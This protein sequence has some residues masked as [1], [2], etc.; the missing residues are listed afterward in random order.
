MAHTKTTPKNLVAKKKK[1]GGPQQPAPVKQMPWEAKGWTHQQ[2]TNWKKQRQPTTSSH[3]ATINPSW[4]TGK[5]MQFKPWGPGTSRDP[6]LP[7]A[8]P[9]SGQETSLFSVSYALH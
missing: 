4:W 2:W 7:E 6:V 3:K 9:A 5:G 8:H 1:Q